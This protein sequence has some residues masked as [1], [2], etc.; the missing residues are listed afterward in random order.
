MMYS[1]RGPGGQP[2]P[3]GMPP[4]QMQHPMHGQPFVPP[5][6][7]PIGGPSKTIDQF[8]KKVIEKVIR[9]LNNEA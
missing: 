9:D 1:N 6:G 2:H 7:G 3:P 4:M 8:N 5:S